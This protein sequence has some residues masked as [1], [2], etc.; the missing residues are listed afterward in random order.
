MGSGL[1]P[2]VYAAGGPLEVVSDVS[3]E[4]SWTTVPELVHRTRELAAEESLA[5]LRERCVS[6]AGDFSGR[7]FAGRVQEAWCALSTAPGHDHAAPSG[8]TNRV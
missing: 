5:A 3:A 6:R 4:L 1:V 7:A 2:L 8:R